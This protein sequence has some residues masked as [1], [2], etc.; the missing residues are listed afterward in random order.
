MRRLLCAFWRRKALRGLLFSL[1]I[2]TAQAQQNVHFE[3]EVVDPSGAIVPATRVVIQT[4]G[5]ASPAASG[6]SDGAG[7][8]RTT[9]AAGSYRI[10]L[11]HDGFKTVEQ[12]VEIGA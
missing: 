4:D 8:F 9:V 11:S 7:D 3:V 5:T 2:P 6:M 10:L 1:L 12:R